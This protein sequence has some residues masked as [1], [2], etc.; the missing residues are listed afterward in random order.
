MNS[1]SNFRIQNEIKGKVGAI[2][3]KARG[4]SIQELLNCGEN[5]EFTDSRTGDD[6][7]ESIAMGEVAFNTLEDPTSSGV[8]QSKDSE[9][10][11]IVSV[12][13]QLYAVACAKRIVSACSRVQ[14]KLLF[15]LHVLQ[16][17]LRREKVSG[18]TFTRVDC[19][20]IYTS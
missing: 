19:I 8:A 20:F 7:I 12:Q 15:L 4:I 6:A 3:Q 18:L 11:R 1:N 2:V 17:G 13:E 5:I 16:K 10:S 9:M 14:N